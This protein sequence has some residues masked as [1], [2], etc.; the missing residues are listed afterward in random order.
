MEMRSHSVSVKGGNGRERVVNRGD[1]KPY[2]GSRNDGEP[3]PNETPSAEGE[4]VGLNPHKYSILEIM[5]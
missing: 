1:A 4:D 2:R 3:K 5:T